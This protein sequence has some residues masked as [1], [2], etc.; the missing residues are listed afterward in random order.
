MKITWTQWKQSSA[1][2]LAGSCTGHTAHSRI[3]SSLPAW[4]VKGTFWRTCSWVVVPHPQPPGR[5]LTSSWSSPST[6]AM[7]KSSGQLEP[8]HGAPL[9]GCAGPPALQSSYSSVCWMHSMS[10]Q[11]CVKPTML[12]SAHKCWEV[13]SSHFPWPAL[14]VSKYRSIQLPV[15]VARAS[16]SLIWKLLN[17]PKKG[18]WNKNYIFLLPAGGYERS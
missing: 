17:K 1:P 11:M 10:S 2:H 14:V 9:R 7:R 8:P 13:C 15:W 5:L 18:L 3:V 4:P 16:H 6:E 12:G